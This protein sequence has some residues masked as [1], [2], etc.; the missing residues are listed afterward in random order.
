MML[1]ESV[2]PPASWWPCACL[3]SV[4]GLRRQEKN[5]NFLSCIHVFELVLKYCSD[6]NER[7]WSQ[8]FFYFIVLTDIAASILKMSFLICISGFRLKIF[9]IAVSQKRLQLES[10]T[11]TTTG[12]FLVFNWNMRSFD[13][14]ISAWTEICM[15]CSIFNPFWR[16]Q[17]FSTACGVFCSVVL[18]KLYLLAV[19]FCNISL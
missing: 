11:D 13:D 12:L 19:G 17:N 9:R 18:I 15:N 3:N 7:N 14:F 8:L 4:S 1:M 10:K 6:I 16:D 5:L 2:N